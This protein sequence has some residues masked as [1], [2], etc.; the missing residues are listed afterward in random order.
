MAPLVW[1][2]T[3]NKRFETGI[4]QAVVYPLNADTGLYDTGFAWNGVYGVNEKPA[5]ASPN[6]QYADN[7]K[8]LSLLSA[9]TFAG[10]IEAYTFPDEFALCDGTAAPADGVSVSQQ[11]RKT[12]GLS[13]RTKIGNDLTPDA[14]YK[15]HLVYGCLVTPSEKDY[16]TINDS[17]AATSFSWDFDCTPVTVTGYQPTCLITIDSTKVDSGALTDLENLLYGT[18]G[19]DP[20]LPAPDDVLALFTGTITAITL[21]P[22]TFDGA[23]TITIPSQTGVTYYVDD[24]EQDAGS[25]TLT[26]GQSKVVSARAAAG[27]VFN[28]PVVTEWLFTYVS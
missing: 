20:S 13:Y 6:A 16:A 23:D 19:T 17:P 7:V 3:G 21:E 26:S 2:D 25:V 11:P 1:D 12:F 15:Y 28:T 14:G 24:V 22:A 8:Y 27:Y 5:G 10:T 18:G 9:E 4:D